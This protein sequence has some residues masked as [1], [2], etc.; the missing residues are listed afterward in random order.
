VCVLNEIVEVVSV[1]L[2]VFTWG[3]NSEVTVEVEQWCSKIPVETSRDIKVS[4]EA[5]VD[6]CMCVDGAAGPW[7]REDSRDQSPYP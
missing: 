1:V 5:V 3:H 6:S 7:S 2:S 4:D